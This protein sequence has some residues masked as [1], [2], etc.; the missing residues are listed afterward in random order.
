MPMAIK[1]ALFSMTLVLREFFTERTFG[2]INFISICMTLFAQ[3]Q[4]EAFEAAI[5]I[6]DLVSGPD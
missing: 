4:E 6:P 1:G 2:F 3:R 5:D